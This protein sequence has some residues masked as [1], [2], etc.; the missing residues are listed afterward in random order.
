MSSRASRRSRSARMS[1]SQS[2]SRKRKSVTHSRSRS[3]KHRRM[4]SDKPSAYTGDLTSVVKRV[5]SRGAKHIKASNKLLNQLQMPRKVEW[6]DFSQ[7]TST[8]EQQFVL[9]SILD[10]NTVG[11]MFYY[12]GDNDTSTRT[13]SFTNTAPPTASVVTQ[14]QYNKQTL[15]DRS[16]LHLSSWFSRKIWN[17]SNVDMEIDVY[18]F[19]PRHDVFKIAASSDPEANP[20]P[21]T[22][23]DSIEEYIY[24]ATD[25]DAPP[26][27]ET[28]HMPR[29]RFPTMVQCDSSL[30]D[31]NR[32]TSEFQITSSKKFILAG[33]ESKEFLIK[34]TRQR[35]FKTRYFNQFRQNGCLSL[36][37]LSQHM[38]IVYRYAP[39]IGSGNSLSLIQSVALKYEDHYGFEVKPVLDGLKLHAVF[40]TREQHAF[41]GS[42]DMDPND[43]K[44]GGETAVRFA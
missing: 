17:P 40:D 6:R 32:F 3:K 25:D 38:L 34:D 14:A 16:L 18:F 12:V 15:V 42:A 1:I 44:A 24:S 11:D 13:L 43:N 35:V 33:G 21:Q 29:L 7:V 36:R 5:G 20:V 27:D 41:A 31:V 26:E 39:L 4:G 2:R 9:C 8:T 37:N 28:Y 19:K 30:Y 22:A 23:V 10:P